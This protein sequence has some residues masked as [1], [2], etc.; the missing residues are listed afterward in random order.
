MT[1]NNRGALFMV[2]AMAGFAVEDALI[3]GMGGALPPGQIIAMLGAFGGL[4]LLIVLRLRGVA[5]FPPETLSGPVILRNLSEAFG[6]VCF[7]T[8]LVK[9]DLATASAILQ[10]T[11]LVVT[12]GAVLFLGE[13]VGWRRWAAMSVGFLGVLVILRPGM[14][15]FDPAALWAVGGMLGL[16]F[17]DLATRRVPASMDSLQLSFQAFALLVPVGLALSVTSGLAPL[18][19]TLLGTVALCATIGLFAYWT[20]V[21]AMRLGDVSYVTPFRYSRMVFALFIGIG[22]FGERPDLL[23]WLGI[24]LIIGSGLYTFFRERRVAAQ[25]ATA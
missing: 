23:T 7:V 16:A 9:V 11:P 14:A 18:T 1:P 5:L 24:A 20:I 22:I 10:A 6:T 25:S 12:L 19:P 13:T 8:A 21:S 15:G 3:K 4:A 17:R 2:L